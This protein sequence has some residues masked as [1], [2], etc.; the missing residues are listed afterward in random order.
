MPCNCFITKIM[1]Q[2]LKQLKIEQK[3]FQRSLLSKIKETGTKDLSL[4]DLS[5]ILF[6]SAQ[7]FNILL[8]VE[9]CLMTII[10]DP[11]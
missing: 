7:I 11:I 9:D 1:K 5:G 10:N 8:Q 3:I 4:N 6:V 2:I